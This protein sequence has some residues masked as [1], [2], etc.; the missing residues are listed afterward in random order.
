MTTTARLTLAL[1]LAA[2]VSGALLSASPAPAIPAGPVGPP[3]TRGELGRPF[4]N[5]IGSRDYGATSQNWVFAEDNRGLIYVG[6]NLGALEY[7]GSS[8][9]LIETAN[10]SVVRSLTKDEHGR[11]YVGGTSEIGYLS[12]DASGLMQ[13]VSLLPYVPQKDRDFNDVWTAHVTPQGIYFQSRE[14]LLRLTPPA[15]PQ[16]ATGWTE[17]SWR[18]KGRF[19]YGFWIGGI[20]YVHHQGVGLQRMVGDELETI[21]G[22]EQFAGERLQVLLPL[23]GGGRSDLLVGT[24]NRGLFR[25]DGQSFRPFVTDAD[26][27]FRTR[28]LYK[29]ALL[30]DGT[31]GLTTISG[32]VVIIDVTGHALRY[33][34]QE[35]GLPND[36]GLAMFVD[37]SAT[38][39]VAPEGAVCQVEIPSPLSRFDIK[40]GLSGTVADVVRH[41]GVLYVATGVGVFYLD[42]ATSTFK[43]VTGFREGNSQATGLASNGDV[44]MVGY[45]SGLHQIDGAVAH[46]IKPNIGASFSCG[47]IRYSRQDPKRLWI[48]LED[49]LATMHLDD[50]GRWVDDGRIPGVRETLNVVAEPTPGVLWLGTGAQGTLRVQFPDGSFDHPRIDRYGKAAGLAGDNGVSA[51][52]VDGRPVFVMKQGVFRFDDQRQRF[53][54]DDRFKGVAVGGTQD[55]SA[56]AEDAAGNVWANFGKETAEF[57]RQA[58]GSYTA[59]KTA[60]LRFSDLA[61]SKIFAEP[62]GVV[63]FARDDGLIRYDPSVQKNY[64]ADYPALIRRVTVGEG[65]MLFGGTLLP[66]AP[67]PALAAGENTLRF[68]FT[69]ASYDDVRTTQYQTTLE[70]FDSHWSGWTS[71]SKRDYTNLPSGS[72]RFRVKAR[73]LYQHESAET[74]YA[75]TITPPWYATWWAYALDALLAGGAIFGFVAVRTRGLRAEGRRLEGVV[76]DRTREIRER[77]AEVR[78]QA[79]ELRTIDD[80]VKVINREEGLRDVLHALLEQGM[81]LVP[82]AQK[83]AFLV[84]D[85]DTDTFVF[86]SHLGYPAEQ[87]KGVSLTEAEVTQRYAEGT[88]RV[89][90]GVYIVRPVEHNGRAPI[91]GVPTPKAMVAMTVALR[92]RL[93]GLLVFDNM[94]DPNA[95]NHSDLQRLTRLREHAMAAVAKARTLV[96][97][98]E[99]TTA[100]QHQKEQVEKSYD[101]VE[102]LSRIGRD[103]TAKLSSE[104][105]ISTVYQNVNSLMDAAVFGIGLVNEA[106]QRLE[107]PATKENAVQLPPFSYRLDDDSRLAVVCYTRR[108]E[109]VIEDMPREHSRYI[110]NYKPP[111]AGNPVASL[112]YLPLVYKDRAIGVIT[113][114]S[115]RTHAY[116]DYHLNILR[117]LATY[118]TIALENAD[119]YRQL[120]TTLDRLKS[121]QE[122]LVVQ[123]KLASLGA[124]TAGI[125]HEIKNPLNFVN[126]FAELSSELAEEL[127]QEIERVKDRLEPADFDLLLSLA[128]DLQMNARK[129]NDHG[130]RADSIVRGMLLHSRGQSGERQDTDVNALLEEYVNLSYHGVRAQDSSFNLTVERG[131]DPTVGTIQAVPQ[132]LSRVFLNIVNNACYATHEKKKALDQAGRRDYMPTLTVSTRNAGDTVEIRVR[133]NGEGIPQNIRDRIFNPF[134]TTKPTG[135]GTGLGLSIS[136]DIVVQQHHGTLDVDS[137]AG[138]YTEFVIRLPRASEAAV[139]DGRAALA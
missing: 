110:K 43:Q 136:H 101:N 25:Y 119:A 71:E 78:T 131:Y 8:W 108:Q 60:L 13:Y 65:R 44:L 120:N 92:G 42:T 124:L 2:V 55:E 46:V 27:Y 52:T 106:E 53:I 57:R 74:D 102:L 93:E 11:L 15:D 12:P 130:R 122:Q 125:A 104:E 63:W 64:A 1:G 45:G 29:G 38:L 62:N 113:A 126:N 16:S 127:R 99:K 91:A 79:E 41:K 5:C 133:D 123:E 21:P 6:N 73:N 112:L 116:T 3:A 137:A 132:D 67:A 20:Y 30:P 26:Q 7:D 109:I 117:N 56:I 97:L 86:A 118:A 19:L 4:L 98:Q 129:I 66:G 34:N 85:L 96:T 51:Y 22:S 48:A 114:Q 121:T 35:T 103:I 24:F 115:F 47:A 139:G 39:W 36:N 105:I 82:Q 95:F 37:H 49:G 107:F 94:D 128:S 32:G 18:P 33:I 90:K 58:D 59:E 61:V 54:S 84:R 10:R 87:F 88:E 89:E 28:T 17:R 100:L 23:T 80:I 111:V 81:K 138:Q 77:E 135:Q 134:F 69:A 70:G 9:R 50:H 76:A 75:F 40:V 14:I 83:A 72:F 68:E 31:I